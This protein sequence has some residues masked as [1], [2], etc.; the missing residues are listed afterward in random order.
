MDAAGTVTFTASTTGANTVGQIS[1]KNVV[2]NAGDSLA[3]LTFGG[4]A[5]DISLGSTATIDGSSVTATDVDIVATATATA[6]VVD[7][8]G[9]IAVDKVDVTGGAKTK[10]YTV[11]GDLGLSA[12][13][14]TVTLANYTTDT[15]STVS[16]DLSGV[17]AD[18]ATQSVVVI[19]IDAEVTNKVSV[20]GSKGNNDTV[21]IDGALDYSTKG[22]VLSGVEKL[23]IDDD[24]TVNAST[25]SGQTIAITGVSTDVIT[26]SGTAA[27]DTISTANLT[28]GG[29]SVLTI[30]AGVGADNIT[31][32]AMT[33]TVSYTTGADGADTITGFTTGTDKYD[34]DFAPTAGNFTLTTGAVNTGGALTANTTGVHEVTGVTMPTDVTDGAAVVAAIS[35]GT[36]TVTASDK[37]LLAV[38]GSDTNT[39]LYEAFDADGDA[40]I[41]GTEITLVATFVATDLATGDII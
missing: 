2:I 12:D 41:A 33:E 22:L 4:G 11:K 26:M 9:G 25:L 20:T 13:E 17:V 18:T 28:S 19:D 30:D 1:A 24:I 23:T 15:T 39:Y 21:N 27:A 35:N 37:V 34:T 40:A 14:Y 29:Q 7:V 31:L 8:A 5:T 32:G 16:V 36:I 38:V 6:L 3:G 10:S